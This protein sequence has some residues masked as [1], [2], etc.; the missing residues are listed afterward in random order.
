METEATNVSAEYTTDP[1]APVWDEHALDELREIG[2]DELVKRVVRQ[3][4]RDAEERIEELSETCP[5]AGV[6]T[7]REAAHALHGIALSIG[8]IRLSQ[9]VA[10]TLQREKLEHAQN[11]VLDFAQYLSEVREVLAVLLV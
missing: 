2:G 10:D 6:N 5:E 7:W 11:Y 9:I 8:A 1:D 4:I 3:S